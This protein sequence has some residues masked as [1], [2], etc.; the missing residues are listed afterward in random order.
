M[1]V[2]GVI[3]FLSGFLKHTPLEHI[4]LPLLFVL[5]FFGLKLLDGTKS[6]EIN[7]YSKFFLILKSLSTIGFI[8][9]ISVAFLNTFKSELSLSYNIELLEGLFYLNSLFFI[10]GAIGCVVLLNIKEGLN[11]TQN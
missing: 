2:L 11:S 9:L 10:I 4:S 1:I 6:N 3:I 5:F 7:N 8:L